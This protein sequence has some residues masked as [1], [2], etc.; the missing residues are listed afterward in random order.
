M[1]SGC[2][3]SV[4]RGPLRILAQSDSATESRAQISVAIF[5]DGG[6]AA[7]KVLSEEFNIR[8]E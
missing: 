1:Y 6:H 5:R 3:P 4:S 2:W 8:H 7:F